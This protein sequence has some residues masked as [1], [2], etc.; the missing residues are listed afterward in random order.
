MILNINID[1]D[2]SNSA[3]DEDMSTEVQ[4]ILTKHLKETY[5]LPSIDKPIR[6]TNGNR[7]GSFTATLWTDSGKTLGCY[8]VDTTEAQ[9]HF[10]DSR[11][12]LQAK[13][14]SKFNTEN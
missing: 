2:T 5:L 1:I 8:A 7:V 11:E 14:K 4:N 3:F 12:Y 10:A 13:A 6:D 9:K